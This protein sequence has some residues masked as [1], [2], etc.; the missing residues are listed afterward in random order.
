M[1]EIGLERLAAAAIAASVAIAAAILAGSS[2]AAATPGQTAQLA[3]KRALWNHQHLR[4]YAYRLQ[5]SCFCPDRQPV[6]I[7]V[8]NGVS[9]GGSGF[10]AQLSTV[11]KLFGTIQRALSSPT[12]R[13]AAVHYDLTRGFPRSASIDPIIGAIDDEFGWT[14]TG[15]HRL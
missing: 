11:P 13:V 9:H 8:R 7:T 1:A 10:G 2:G 4:S 6:T 14:I 12:G 15:F 3:Q 5:I